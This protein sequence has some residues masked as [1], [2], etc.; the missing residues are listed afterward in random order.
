MTIF[1]S[2][3]LIMTALIPMTLAAQGKLQFET[4]EWDF[5]TILE[6][7]GRVSHTFTG[8]NVGNAPIVILDVA[9]TCGC[10]VPAFSKQ[11]I[12]PGQ[13]TSIMVTY[14]PAN[15]PGIFNKELWV[16]SSER[17]R[18]ATL[19]I[20]GDV[21]PRVKSV[22]ELYPI[23]AGNGLGLTST[24]C[25]FAY[26]YPGQA[27]QSAIGCA[28]LS[29]HTI[30]LELR[31][32]AES[33]LL[34]LKYP[35]QLEPG[36]RAQ[37]DISYLIPADKPRYGTLRDVMEVV[38]NGRSNGT[39]LVFHAIG[40]DTP[41]AGA[42]SRTA[43]AE[44]SENFLKFGPIRRSGG[45]QRRTLTLSNAGSAELIVRAVECDAPVWVSLTPGRKIAPGGSAD[46][47]VT[48][49]PAGLDY[50]VL[51]KHMTIVTNDPS[52]P[53]RRLRVTAIVED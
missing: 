20:R 33:G 50:G 36:Q 22:E 24:L 45:V 13:E 16:Y 43:K 32:E 17:K 40:V 19:R 7:D 10:T 2:I 35:R 26:L 18:I 15:R 30:R 41:P 31:S 1:R 49:D 14:D 29:Q 48:V 51:S 25:A 39:T 11:P 46:F 21:T 44:F 6:T 8:R 42:N 27:K 53:M 12:L 23:D 47:E 34:R 3:A 37:I 28:N 9:T 5:G 38:V 52:R 4:P